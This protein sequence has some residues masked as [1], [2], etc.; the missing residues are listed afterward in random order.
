MLFHS[1]GVYLCGG[2][3]HKNGERSA[4]RTRKTTLQN[5]TTLLM[6]AGSTQAAQAPC[7]L[8]S[9]PLWQQ[10]R[11]NSPTSCRCNLP[12]NFRLLFPT[13][14]KSKRK[15]GSSPGPFACRPY[16]GLS[17]RQQFLSLSLEAASGLQRSNV[18]S[19]ASKKKL[20]R[21]LP[22]VFSRSWKSNWATDV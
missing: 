5:P 3:L 6:L 2:E 18:F 10:L 7:F 12:T 4:L 19:R 14:G 11:K 13:P 21:R 15:G 22:I 20:A 9:P 1:P 8:G 17:I 16:Y